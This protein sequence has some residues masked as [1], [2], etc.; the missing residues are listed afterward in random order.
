MSQSAFCIFIDSFCEGRVPAWHD[1]KNLPVV[2]PT[3]EAAQREIADDIMER[4]QQFLD[5]ERPFDDATT[6]AMK[7]G[8][9]RRKN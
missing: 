1:E 2:Y 5:G 7:K 3:V 9:R 8:E 4:L 6:R